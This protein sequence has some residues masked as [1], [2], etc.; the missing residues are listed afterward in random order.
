MVVVMQTNDAVRLSW[1]QA[2]L[3]E[4]G[5]ACLVLDEHTS[6]IEGSIGAIPRRIVVDPGD[7]AAARR[8]LDLAQ[9]ELDDG[10]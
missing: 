9:A 3:A 7:H 10:R 6:A 4:R 1:A 5:I 2:V 8:A